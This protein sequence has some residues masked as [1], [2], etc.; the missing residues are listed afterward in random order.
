[1]RHNWE[2]I[3]LGEVIKH[4]QEFIRIDDFK[5]YKLCRVQTKALGVVLRE[6]KEG[7]EIKTKEQQLCK[8]NDLIFAEMDARFGGYGIIP[9]NLNGSIVSSHY[10]LYEINQAKIEK[11]FLEYCMKM[12]WFLSQVEAKGSTNYA[13][14][15]PYQ[16]LDY[17]IP[18]PNLHEQQ[19]IVSKIECVKK[20]IE[21]IKKLKVEQEKNII[22]LRNSIFLDLQKE[23]NNIPIGRALIPHD[24]IVEINPD[25]TYK[26]VKVR[27]EHKGVLLRGMIKG[28]EIGSKQFLANENDFIISKIDARNGAMGMIPAELDGAVVT[29]D[30]PLFSFSEE[31]NPKFFYYFSNTFY[32]DDACKKASEGTTNR[33]RLKMGRFENILIP[34]PPIEEQNR[35]VSLLDKLNKIKTSHK[36]TEKELNELMPSLLDKAFKGEL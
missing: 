7:F 14:I 5:K 20:S 3:K 28:N 25:E 34:F 26:Q 30:F 36:Q 29:N 15:R 16:V 18:F 35:I 31:V 10:F 12:P 19:R 6:E 1:M 17:E 27:M 13:A 24:E 2:N 22:F 21:Q 33:K 32:F 8:E 9:N 11:Q 4:K 23:Y